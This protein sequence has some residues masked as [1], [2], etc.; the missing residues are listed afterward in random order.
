[1]Q[2]PAMA[3]SGSNHAINQQHIDQLTEQQHVIHYLQQHQR[4]PDYYVTKQQA[5][6]QGWDARRGNLCQVLPGKA[7]GGDRFFN[8]EGQLPMVK[9]RQWREADIN[10]RCGHRGSDRLLYSN[11]QL[12]FVTHDHY[13]SFIRIE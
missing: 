4:L 8:R 13:Q 10:Y 9:G 5:R 12:I 1:M 6:E 3:A 7:I 11:D 2:Q